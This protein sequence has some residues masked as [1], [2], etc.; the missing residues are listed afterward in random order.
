MRSTHNPYENAH[1]PPRALRNLD[2]WTADKCRADRILDAEREDFARAESDRKRS[3]PDIYAA[4]RK[5]LAPLI[6]DQRTIPR[7]LRVAVRESLAARG[8]HD[9]PRAAQLAEAALMLAQEKAAKDPELMFAVLLGAAHLWEPEGGWK[10]HAPR[11]PKTDGFRSVRDLLMAAFSEAEIGAGSLPLEIA[12]NRARTRSLPGEVFVHASR[13][14]SSHAR[15]A[16]AV[17]RSLDAQ[18]LIARA[19]LHPRDVRLLFERHVLGKHTDRADLLDA[20]RQRAAAVLGIRL[21]PRAGLTEDDWRR[22]AGEALHGPPAPGESPEA[23]RVARHV[24]RCDAAL[25]AVHD[26]AEQA[27]RVAIGQG[28]RKPRQ[29]PPAPV[30]RRQ[31]ATTAS[32]HLHAR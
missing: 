25:L 14:G 26:E 9:P 20:L 3:I 15:N 22:Q 19:H 27:L 10:A 24:R 18:R 4:A 31:R 32:E 2:D 5:V 13:S 8:M 17:E 11:P 23:E 29:K 1:G 21:P 12:Q 6:E 30:P 16:A 28:R 7:R